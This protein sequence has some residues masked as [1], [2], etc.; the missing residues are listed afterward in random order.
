MA[1]TESAYCAVRTGP[2]KN[3]TPFVLKGLNAVIKYLTL[4]A[5]YRTAKRGPRTTANW[6]NDLGEVIMRV[7]R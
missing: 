3:R 4:A 2:S 5:G 1:Q 6:N 7:V